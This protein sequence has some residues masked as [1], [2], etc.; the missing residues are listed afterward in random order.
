MTWRT[1]VLGGVA[2]LWLIAGVQGHPSSGVGINVLATLGDSPSVWLGDSP[3]VW[4]GDSPSVWL[5]DSPVVWAF[6]AGMGALLPDLDAQESKIK[7]LSVFGIRPFLLP[8]NFLHR[9]LGHRGMLHSALGLMLMALVIG[10]PAGIGLGTT[11]MMALILGIASHLALDASTKSGIPLWFPNPQRMHLL[12]S[13]LRIT[14]GSQAEDGVLIALAL[15]VAAYFL[16]LNGD[17]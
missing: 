17:F 16:R 7:N 12:P 14:T 4:L 9:S 6:C 2:A 3:S 15:L 11:A 8:A 5:G 1:H 10:I 13:Q